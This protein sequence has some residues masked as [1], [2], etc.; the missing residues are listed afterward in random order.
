MVGRG[1]QRIWTP[2]PA[3]A[4]W[5]LMALLGTRS[6]AAVAPEE[7]VSGTQLAS[8]ESSVPFAGR[9]TVDVDVALLLLDEGRIEGRSWGKEENGLYSK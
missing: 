4:G 7:V 9:K 3:R 5:A 2:A 6:G 8:R 1:P